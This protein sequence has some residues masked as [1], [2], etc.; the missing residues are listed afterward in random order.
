MDN[1]TS[2]AP[3]YSDKVKSNHVSFLVKS[4]NRS[5]SPR[6]SDATFTITIKVQTLGAFTLGERRAE[7]ILLYNGN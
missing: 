7:T 2:K 3:P 6:T 1:D 5:C 4:C